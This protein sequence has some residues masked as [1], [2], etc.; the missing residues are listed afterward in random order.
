MASAANVAG[1]RTCTARRS[2]GSEFH[3]CSRRLDR[4][5]RLAELSPEERRHFHQQVIPNWQRL[6]PQRKQGIMRRLN[7]LRPLSD[8]E[9]DRR[10]NDPAFTQ[11]MSPDEAEILRTFSRLR[12]GPGANPPEPHP[13]QP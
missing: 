6:E 13:D 8:E 10:L 3:S 12:L 1:T 4:E 5:H 7:A 9:R 2:I 11:G